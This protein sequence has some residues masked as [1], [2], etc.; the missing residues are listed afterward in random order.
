MELIKIPAARV[1]NLIGPNGETKK[2]LEGLTSTKIEVNIEGEATIEGE[3]ANEFFAKDVVKA[4]GRGFEPK[5]A[6][7]LL[8]DKF[9]LEIMDLKEICRSE[10]EIQRVKGRVIG[11]DG[12]MKLEIESATDSK[13]SVYGWTVSV[14]SP[15]D[16]MVYAQKAI[17]RIIDG[18]QLTTVFNDLA[19]YKR[20]IFANRLMGK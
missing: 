3:S 12:K 7:N 17:N 5:D 13:V 11:E 4:I 19:K 14:I 20:E 10:N 15:M 16:S 2:R 6:E 18:A 8:S 1:G 9:M